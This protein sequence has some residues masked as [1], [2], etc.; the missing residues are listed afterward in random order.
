MN[1]F[2]HGKNIEITEALREYIEDKIGRVQRLLGDLPHVNIHVQLTTIKHTHQFEVTIPLGDITIRAEEA[3]DDMYKAIDLV[4]EKL[5]RKIRKI[6]T[7]EARH[8]HTPIE[9]NLTNYEES[10]EDTNEVVRVKHFDIKPMST[11]EAILQMNLLDHN[12][13]VF[14]DANTNEMNV[15]YKRKAGDYGLIQS[16]G[17]G[18]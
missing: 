3:T 4:E 8:I 2:I 14:I 16:T 10:E 15:V 9:N 6:K 12:F 18:V 13:F 7:K 1:I 17:L 5:K 11:E